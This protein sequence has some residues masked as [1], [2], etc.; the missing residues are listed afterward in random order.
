[1]G[2]QSV[3]SSKALLDSWRP[4]FENC[5]L[6]I[7]RAQF[8]GAFVDVNLAF[9]DLTGYSQGELGRMML[10]DLVPEDQHAEFEELMTLLRVGDQ[11]Q[12]QVETR[13]RKKDNTLVWVEITMFV[14]AAPATSCS[15][16]V[17]VAKDISARKRA[18]ENHKSQIML[19]ETIFDVIPVMVVFIGED[20]SL[21]LVNREWEQTFG[22]S[23]EEALTGNQDILA[24]CIPEPEQRRRA[25]E[26]LANG[27]YRW[28]EFRLRTKDG[29]ILDT[30][31]AVVKLPDGTR[32]NIGRDITAQKGF[33]EKLRRSEAHL[34]EAQRLS[35][36]GSWSYD[37]CRSELH[38]SAEQLRMAGFDPGHGPISNEELR[39]RVHPE[40]R[41]N[42]DRIASSV[43]TSKRAFSVDFRYLLP[44]GSIKYARGVGQPVLT[45]DGS[46]VEFI[47]V[48]ADL[49][50]SKLVELE[51]QRSFDQLRA[52]TG[53]VHTAQED[54]RKRVAREIHDELGQALTLIKFDISSLLHETPVKSRLHE[55]ALNIQRHVDE[56]IRFIRRI[57]TE[58]RPEILSDLGL[59]AAI[60]WAAEEFQSRT[61][62]VCRVRLPAVDLPPDGD[63]DTALFRIFQ[64]T[65]TNIVRHS[66]ATCVDVHLSQDEA[67]VKLNVHDNGRG[68]TRNELDAPL[69][70]GIRGMKERALLLDGEVV[71]RSSPG[72]GTTVSASIPLYAYK[73]PPGTRR[74]AEQT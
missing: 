40:D 13:Y 17:C 46:L 55:K 63:C 23:R 6:A 25:K 69:A 2:G 22:W 48:I 32:V 50:D 70:L 21:K 47:G 14:D 54:E 53:R 5:P 16:V 38:F 15:F 34:A 33:E 3:G 57:S 39:K 52:L 27:Q 42:F 59:T 30:T 12:F 62:I 73:F 71:I 49:T 68:A 41:E 26:F 4:I 19:W 66:N 35:H 72:L 1:M 7:A 9:Q 61:G 24:V 65:L 11:D 44:D 74:I 51:R 36:I 8:D 45:E 58:L 64:E 37:P 67:N 20:D 56:S 31:W 28:T 29:R 43:G 10:G 60:E 18:D